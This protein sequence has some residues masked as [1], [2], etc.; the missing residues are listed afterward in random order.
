MMP[1]EWA[2]CLADKRVLVTGAAGMTGTAVVQQLLD[3]VPGVRIR[4][5]WRTTPPAVD[6]PRVEWV[7][8]DLTHRR[9]CREL[10]R[11]VDAVIMAAAVT[12]GARALTTAAETQV[13]DNLVVDAMLLEACGLEGVERCVFFSTASLYQPLVG[14]I[15]EDQLDRNESP[16][17]A[18]RGIGFVKRAS[19]QLCQFWHE[20][21]GL[22]CGI[23]RAANIYGPRAA[24]DPARSNFIPA[25]IRKACDRLD[26]FEVWGSPDVVRDVIFVGD[27]SAAAVRLLAA[28]DL[29]CETYNLGTGIP[30]TVGEV[31]RVALQAACHTPSAVV[32]SESGPVTVPARVLDC[33]AL[34]QRLDWSPQMSFEQGIQQT[35]DWWQQHKE[36]WE[37]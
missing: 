10:A 8:A 32:Y 16:H 22:R 25:L 7:R 21:T 2:A 3:A 13:T 24:F 14:H 19:E 37:R 34:S 27:A 26:P 18:H 20:R 17:P 33:S 5:A 9:A 6:D 23:L 31:V 11:D 30:C 29:G 36:S 28:P 1:T 4:A 35:L 15:R 12:G